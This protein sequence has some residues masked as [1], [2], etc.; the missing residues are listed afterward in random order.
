MS[1]WL[2][3]R[4]ELT[5]EQL[6]AVELSPG[7][8]RVILGG[9]GSGK[10]QI[11]LHRAHFLANHFRSG[12]ERFRVM[13]YTN[14]LKHYIESAFP[15]LDLPPENVLTFDDW[16]LHWHKANIRGRTPWDT[17]KK[18]PDFAAI[19]RAVTER[20][21]GTR[22]PLF[23]FVLV[24]EGQDMEPEVFKLLRVIARHVTVCLDHKQQLYDNRSNEAMILSALGLRKRNINLL[25]GFRCSPYLVRL[26][27]ELI[28]DETERESFINQARVAPQ[29][30]ETP[31]LYYAPGEDEMRR[32]EQVIRERQL[33]GDRIAVLFPTQRKLFG[34]AKAL[35]ERGVEL[36]TQ[37]ELDFGTSKPKF[38]TY[39]SAKGLTFDS[40]LMPRL[41]LDYSWKM[42]EARLLKLLFVGITRATRW[43]YLSATESEQLSALRRLLPLAERGDLTIQRADIDRGTVPM[44]GPTKPPPSRP[45]LGFL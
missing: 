42:M 32:L 44:N 43:A 34:I 8:H 3:P 14:V 24:D 35:R 13:V 31:L 19:R 11:L 45:D 38:I 17:E 39:Y 26:A 20:L 25:E 12:P 1:T 7:E 23:D 4:A 16:C 6:R 29:Q 27:A 10:T 33:V 9:P 30:K 36:E 21:S 5:P 15:L 37:K 28:D 40:V 22:E 41:V 18:Q 2:I